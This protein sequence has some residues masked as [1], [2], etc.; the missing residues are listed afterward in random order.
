MRALKLFL[1]QW[2]EWPARSAESTIRL[3][4][5]IAK[6]IPPVLSFSCGLCFLR[7]RN[8][9][10]GKH[11]MDND[12]RSPSRCK[13][14]RYALHQPA[15]HRQLCSTVNGGAIAFGTRNRKE[16]MRQKMPFSI[17]TRG[18]WAA[19]QLESPH[20]RLLGG[21][22]RCGLCR[23]C[24]SDCGSSKYHSHRYFLLFDRHVD[25]QW[26][27]MRLVGHFWL[28]S[29]P[30]EDMVSNTSQPVRFTY[31][32]KSASSNGCCFTSKKSTLGFGP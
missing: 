20:R 23:R 32:T 19:S 18:V 31:S 7:F 16:N 25:Q 15:R 29:A 8:L 22:K 14:M 6:D 28:Y 21:H 9:R 10:D 27:W 24:S 2:K 30:D 13:R 11:P 26:P 12:W 4:S 5:S 1:L 3:E 17:F